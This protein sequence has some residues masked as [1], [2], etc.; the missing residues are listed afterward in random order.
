MWEADRAPE[1]ELDALRQRVLGCRERPL[2][3]QADAPAS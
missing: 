3:G 2:E 1:G